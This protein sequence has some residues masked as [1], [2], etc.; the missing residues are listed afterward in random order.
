MTDPQ[1][2]RAIRAAIKAFSPD[3]SSAWWLATTHLDFAE[4]GDE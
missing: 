1:H 2:L 3:H 4:V